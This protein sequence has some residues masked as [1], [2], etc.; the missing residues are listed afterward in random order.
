MAT[1]VSTRP[2]FNFS[3][4]SGASANHLSDITFVGLDLH[5]VFSSAQGDWATLTLQPY[6][7]KLSNQHRRPSFS[8]GKDDWGLV[9]RIFNLNY[10]GLAQ[11]QINLR[12]G[13]M[14]V[15]FGLEQVV[16]T[17]GTLRDY[18]HS[19]NIGVK[20]DWGVSLNGELSVLEY[21]VALLR[22]SG[23]AYSSR[24]APYLVAGRVGSARDQ[25]IRF[26]LSAYH[27]DVQQRTGTTTRTR[28]GLDAIVDWHA[29]SFLSEVT[30]GKDAGAPAANG[31]LEIDWTNRDETWLVY[32]QIRVFASGLE[33]G[34][35]TAT[36]NAL[37]LRFT[38]DAHWAFAVQWVQDLVNSSGTARDGVASLQ[39]RC[40]Y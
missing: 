4:A 33:P 2:A 34:W 15:P 30:A 28:V 9:Y 21:E 29:F 22:G 38:P 12:V 37:G 14:E 26:G 24:D 39:L 13:H 3:E 8:T 11:N 18:N 25:P 40:R 5:K 23:N 16:N 20:S 17:N 19:K 10:T 1:D 27:G 6:I 32:D 36:S 31:T 35:S 7:T